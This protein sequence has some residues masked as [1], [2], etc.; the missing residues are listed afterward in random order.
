M[1]IAETQRTGFELV[2][3]GKFNAICTNVTTGATMVIADSGNLGF[4]VPVK[5]S[6]V[7][8]CSVINKKLTS[9]IS[10]VKTAADYNGGKPVTGP[11]SHRL[12]PREPR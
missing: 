9:K 12:F 10:I 8:S 6:D 7:I 5:K 2:K 1:T 11:D 4:T 3:Q